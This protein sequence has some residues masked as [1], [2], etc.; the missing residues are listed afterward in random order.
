MKLTI[1]LCLVLIISSCKNNDKP[2]RVESIQGAWILL[3]YSANDQYFWD[4]PDQ[5]PLGFRFYSPDS[6]EVYRTNYYAKAE[7]FVPYKITR[8]S[9]SIFHSDS[10]GWW[11]H[12]SV[13][14]GDTLLTVFVGSDTLVYGRLFTEN[15]F[16]RPSFEKIILTVGSG[17]GG[18]ISAVL[19][20][21]GKT[22]IYL[23]PRNGKSKPRFFIR[24]TPG[25]YSKL[26]ES[27]YW[28]SKIFDQDKYSYEFH[29]QFDPGVSYD[30]DFSETLM[31]GKDSVWSRDKGALRSYQM[32]MLGLQ[33]YTFTKIFKEFRLK[34]LFQEI[35]DSIK[36]DSVRKAALPICML[37]GISNH[38]AVVTLM[39]ESMN[40]VRKLKNYPRKDLNFYFR[41]RMRTGAE[42]KTIRTDG[43]LI[44]L[45]GAYYDMDFDFIDILQ[46]KSTP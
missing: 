15:S 31:V 39:S 20:P 21:N 28:T 30:G 1:A 27:Y 11:R 46:S 9:L 18:F 16:A 41:T 10:L 33:G 19:Y 40:P 6:A 3:S 45:E 12:R 2:S 29:S 38:L 32:D 7:R 24:Q 34:Q 26:I 35:P 44:E 14:R 22:C 43:R 17:W 36:C 8:D 42:E 13:N 4:K 23:N 5:V 37:E 25:L